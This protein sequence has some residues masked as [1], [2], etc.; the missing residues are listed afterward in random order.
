MTIARTA[1]RL[2]AA[3]IIKG[4]TGARPTIAEGRVYDSRIADIQP[5]TFSEDAKPIVIVLTDGEEGEQ[6]SKQNGGPPFR[7]MVDLV[8]ELAMVQKVADG[9]DFVVGYPDTDARHEASLDFLEFQIMRELAIGQEPIAIQFRK[10]ARIVKEDS[11]RQVMDDAGVKVACRVLTLVCDTV[12]DDLMIVNTADTALT[13]FN[14]LPEPLRTIAGLLPSG[15]SGFDIC[16]V[17]A[18]ALTPIAAPP[19]EDI[20]FRVD[21]GDEMEPSDMVDVSIEIQSAFD[22]PQVVAVSSSVEIDYARG[23]FQNLI[24][25]ANVTSISIIGWPRVGKTGRLVLQI[26][27]TGN[28]SAT[29]WPTG[30]VWTG[31]FAPTVTQGAGKRDIVV[32]TTP[33]AGHDIF[34]NVVGQNYS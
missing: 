26:T 2:A 6:L 10:I 29:G 16:T 23:T 21:A 18:A 3:Q 28:Y 14:R 25:A 5:E 12:D 19:L 1:L 17:M 4:A 24:L 9:A 20:A 11:H 31:G 30:T 22:V 15:S 33:N 7:R 27:N 32:L 8:L 34:G 13:G